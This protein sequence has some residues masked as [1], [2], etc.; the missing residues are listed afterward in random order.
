VGSSV[1][2]DN[3]DTQ[4]YGDVADDRKRIA[5]APSDFI[6][7]G[8]RFDDETNTG[9]PRASLTESELNI[10]PQHGSGTSTPGTSYNFLQN[11]IVKARVE[12]KGNREVFLPRDSL[13]RII[14]V[15]NI[16]K[17]LIKC[18]LDPPQYDPVWIA[19]RVWEVKL[20]EG[21]LTTRCKIFAVLAMMK[22]ST[23]ILDVLAEDIY[24]DDLP[25]HFASAGNGIFRKQ[26]SGV[27]PVPVQF[28][29]DWEI[30]EQDS[31]ERYQWQMI[32]PYFKLSWEPGQTIC[33]YRLE[34]HDI[35]PFVEETLKE[36]SPDESVVFSG[37][38]STVHI[39]RIHK[40]H[41]KLRSQKVD[42]PFTTIPI[43]V[44][45]CKAKYRRR[46]EFLFC[47]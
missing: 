8:A 21:R 7:V 23:A 18:G 5:Y 46:Q 29:Q 31:F 27:D 39:V 40:A 33:D 2:R 17:E 9:W 24:D 45:D 30:H 19:E 13:E 20:R 26:K 35:L 12:S 16:E 41:Y 6:H 4:Y 14:T 37:G 38:Q 32:A 28:L 42:K 34:E 22:K 3:G 1:V 15:P 25:F 47:C 36:S 10:R 44:A 11:A 43:H